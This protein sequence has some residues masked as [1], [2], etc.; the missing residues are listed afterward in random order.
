MNFD[1]ADFVAND[2]I[3]N[4]LARLQPL[5]TEC[6]RYRNRGMTTK[7]ALHAKRTRT[8]ADDVIRYTAVPMVQNLIHHLARIVSGVVNN[9][10]A[11]VATVGTLT[12]RT[13]S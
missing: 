2:K 4:G 3:G 8:T 13:L 11:V 9:A 1:G 5:L 6:L 10:A 12:G 7:I